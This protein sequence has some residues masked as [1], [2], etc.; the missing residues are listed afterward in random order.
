MKRTELA[1]V[2]AVLKALTKGWDLVDSHS[3][4]EFL[5]FVN[6]DRDELDFYPQKSFV[7]R[8]ELSGLIENLD[9]KGSP[10]REPHTFFE[11]DTSRG[12]WK[13]I[14]EAGSIL[15]RY[16]V[17]PK[18]QKL[19]RDAAKLLGRQIRPLRIAKTPA[20]IDKKP[21]KV[22]TYD[23]QAIQKIVAAFVQKAKTQ[24]E[25][26]FSP[27]SDADL[28]AY[29]PRGLLCGPKIWQELE[30]LAV[31]KGLR[32]ALL[33]R[34][35]YSTS[36][37]KRANAVTL[38]KDKP[39]SAPD[40]VRLFW[41]MLHETIKL[42]GSPSV[43]RVE[44]SEASAY[45]LYDQ[46]E[47]DDFPSPNLSSMGLVFIVE[48]NKHQFIVVVK[49]EIQADMKHFGPGINWVELVGDIAEPK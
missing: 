37:D 35:T 42:D 4:I 32:P 45:S 15:F 3:E 8:M 41:Q 40:E 47:K 1:E 33:V 38:V 23:R 19:L 43:R 18:G 21:L 28:S 49:S 44:A 25:T 29:S 7:Q 13:E 6:E 12:E 14:T 24:V 11:G 31:R 48:S 17:T 30:P 2:A 22:V 34:H 36:D 9:K 39:F 10:V 46:V 16:R 20:E 5:V 27:K 26:A